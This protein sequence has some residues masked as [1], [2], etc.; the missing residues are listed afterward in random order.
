MKVRWM[1]GWVGG[2]TYRGHR[3]W[4]SRLPTRSDCYAWMGNEH[5]EL[6]GWREE[7]THRCSIR[8]DIGLESMG[9]RG[10]SLQALS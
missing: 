10:T 8:G 2:L 6:A 4:D 1:C 9:W 3:L 7:R 5:G